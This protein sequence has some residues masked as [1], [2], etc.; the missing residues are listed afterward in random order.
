MTEV[1]MIDGFKC[2]ECGDLYYRI[3]E[4]GYCDET[5]DCAMADEDGL[6]PYS[7]VATDYDLA[8]YDLAMLAD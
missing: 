4:W 1:K 5:L 2:V 8:N 3:P 6:K 7:W